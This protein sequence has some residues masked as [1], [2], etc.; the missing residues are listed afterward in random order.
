MAAPW[1]PVSIGISQVLVT[2]VMPP[3][4]LEA[5]ARLSYLEQENASLPRTVEVPVEVP[6]EVRIE[7]P[8]IPKASA[9]AWHS[10]ASFCAWNHA[11]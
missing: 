4:G 2:Y 1:G 5:E 8:T 9:R 7:I 11:F 10:K 3:L 6:V